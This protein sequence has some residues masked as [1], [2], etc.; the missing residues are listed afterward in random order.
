MKSSQWSSS[1]AQP[2]WSP[3]PVATAPLIKGAA[4]YFQL[5]LPHTKVQSDKSHFS[6]KIWR[7]NTE[8]CL[9]VP[10]WSYVSYHVDFPS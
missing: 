9:I 5:K 6:D 2:N 7:H 4:F 8:A 1:Q 3:N 10:K